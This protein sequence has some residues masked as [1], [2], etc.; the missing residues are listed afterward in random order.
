MKD[1]TFYKTC[2]FGIKK[3]LIHEH[4]NSKEHKDIENYL[5]INCMT[6]CELCKR[7]IRNDD[8]REHINSPKHLEIEEK[9]Y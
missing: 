9:N 7:K 8:W 3:P 1:I 4:I 6:Y 2:S 5:I